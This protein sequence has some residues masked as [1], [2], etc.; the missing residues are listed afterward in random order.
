M[1]RTESPLGSSLGENLAMPT[2]R[3][4]TPIMPPATPCERLPDGDVLGY[5]L[6]QAKRVL[7]AFTIGAEGGNPTRSLPI[8]RPI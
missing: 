6:D 1:P 7:V 4:T 2:W 5:P 3:L 8:C